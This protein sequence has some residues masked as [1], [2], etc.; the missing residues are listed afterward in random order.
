MADQLDPD[1]VGPTSPLYGFCSSD[2]VSAIPHG[3]KGVPP[4]ASTTQHSTAQH[5]SS[6]DHVTD[7]Q[8]VFGTNGEEQDASKRP[9]TAN[10]PPGWFQSAVS[11]AYTAYAQPQ[12]PDAPNR[13]SAHEYHQHTGYHQAQMSPQQFSGFE[14]TNLAGHPQQPPWY[15]PA[16]VQRLQG[17]PAVQ[18]EWNSVQSDRWQRRWDCTRRRLTPQSRCSPRERSWEIQQ[19]YA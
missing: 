14:Q 3:S 10:A 18:G 12:R 2:V 1:V 8:T 4:R 16:S 19:R 13:F 7:Q 11:P 5:G 6:S 9:P 15:P 17:T